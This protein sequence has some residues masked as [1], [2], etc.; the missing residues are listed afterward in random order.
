MNVR[1]LLLAVVTAT[2]VLGAGCRGC[3]DTT[4]AVKP[5]VAVTPTQL[6]FGQ[7]KVGAASE[8]P[9]KLTSESQTSVQILGATFR[10]GAIPGSASAYEVVALPSSVPQFSDESFQVRF[11]PTAFQDYGATL[12]LS[13]NDEERPQ[14]EVTL[15]GEGAHPNMSVIPECNASLRCTGTV[16]LEPR[17]ID[18]GEEPLQRAVQIPT[19]ELPKV[20]VINESAVELVV[21]RLEIQGVDSSAFT[22]DP[23][24]QLP[25][26]GLTLQ[27]GEGVNFSI[28]FRP[29][30]ASQDAYQAELVV[31]GDDPMKPSVTV[32]LSGTRRDDL[33]PIVC[34]NIIRV[35]PEGETELRYDSKEAWDLVRTPPASGYDFTATRDIRPKSEVRFSAVSDVADDRACTSD[36]EDRRTGLTWSWAVTKAPA[37]ARSVALSGATTPTPVLT[38]QSTVA[39]GEY[40]VT[41]TV[42]DTQ[43]NSTT[44]PIRFAVVP[45]EDLVVELSWNGEQGA[46]ANVDLDL[47]VVRPSSTTAG[48]PFS[49]VFGYFNEGANGETSGD[50]NGVSENLRK[51]QGF[52]F[53]WGQPGLFDDPRLLVDDTGSGQLIETI[54][55]NFPE[56]D[57][58]CATGP[59]TYKVLVH[60]FEDRR[61]HASPALCSVDLTSCQ[62]GESCSCTGGERCVAD[63]APASAAPQGPGKCY[64]PPE[65]EVRIFV[66]AN[67][68]P[69]AVIPLDTLMPPDQVPLGAPCQMLY[70]ADIVWPAKAMG[71]AGTPDGGTEEVPQVIV[72][73]AG[74]DGRITPEIGR[75]GE[76]AAGGLSCAPNGTSSTN[77]PWYEVAPR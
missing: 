21:T 7:V 12:V 38:P 74:G 10:D 17:T 24:A 5:V 53:N 35:K 6:N 65:P 62:D 45:R 14:V 48:Q 54:S 1:Q 55:L 40:E 32:A 63:Q 71:D 67:P 37:G 11:R 43:Q 33:P 29:T 75:F 49:G 66:K 64:D 34:A 44:V 50:I 60:Y 70:V 36:P 30:L 28:R 59:C 76:R 26:G 19:T 16:T 13:T 41:L 57:A 15:A 46:W 4:R 3:D 52:D 2:C 8:L 20:N 42:T 18:F 47:H 58:A 69:V 73:G 56:N 61:V 25:A 39:T 51:A 31:E 68:T 72:R 77:E 23:P 27:P 9:V 22:F